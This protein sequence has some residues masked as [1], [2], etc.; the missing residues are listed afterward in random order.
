MKSKSLLVFLLALWAS[1]V[2]HAWDFEEHLIGYNIL[3]GTEVEVDRIINSVI[4]LYP[5]KYQ[6]VTIPQQVS[7]QNVS[8]NVIGIN[9]NA[10]YNCSIPVSITLPEG[11][12]TI[13]DNAFRGCSSLTNINLPESLTS[14]GDYAFYGCPNLTIMTIPE[15]LTSIGNYVFCGCS[16]PTS[17]TIPESLTDIGDYAFSSCT[18]LNSITLPE[19]V[20]SIGDHTFYRCSSLTSITLPESLTNIGNN[21]FHNCSSLTTITLPENL[22]TIGN[23]A[24][25]ACS[26]LANINFPEGLTSIGE[27]AFSG[28][29]SLTN[30]IIPEGITSIMKFAFQGCS[31]LTSITLPKTLTCIEIRSFSACSNLTNINLPAGLTSIEENAFYGCS[32]LTSITLPKGLTSIGQSAFQQCS[33]LTS[34]NAQIQEPFSIRSIDFYHISSDCVL[35]V[36]AGTKDAYI[37]KG[38][39]TD[40]F[41]GG[42]VEMDPVIDFVDS[43]VKAICV[44]NWDTNTDG[45]LSFAEAAAVTSLGEVFKEDTEITSF[46]E[47]QYFTELRSI[48]ELE[49]YNCS[50]L[51]SVR[52]P[53]KVSTIKE[54]A[55]RN[56]SKLKKLVIE[57]SSQYLYCYHSY[58]YNSDHIYSCFSDCPLETVYLGRDLQNRQSPYYVSRYLGFFYDKITLS[59]LE[60]GKKVTKIEDLMFSGCNGLT[61][62]SIPNSVTSIGKQSFYYCRNLASVVIPNS[63]TYIGEY[64][65]SG[66]GS[67]TSVVSNIQEPFTFGSYAFGDKLDNCV[68]TVPAG[69][70]DAYI[71]AG[72][73]EEVF[74]GG[75][76][77]MGSAIDFADANVKALCVDNWDTNNDGE[78]SY[79]E[80][81]AVT[82]LGTVFK[83]NTTITSFDE[84]Q[85]FTGLTS[86][87]EFAFNGCRGLLSVTFPEG[88]TEIGREAFEYSGLTSVKFPATMENVQE[89]AFLGCDNL[90]SID[91][92]N[93]PAVLQPHAFTLCPSLEYV[94]IPKTVKLWGWGHF[95]ICENLKT[96][97]SEAN[98]EADWWATGSFDLCPSLETISVPNVRSMGGNFVGTGESLQSVTILGG[99][100]PDNWQHYANKMGSIPP[101]RYLKFNIPDGMAES[102]LKHG[103]ANLSDL[104]ALPI[105]KE[106][107]EAEATRI[108]AMAGEIGSGAAGTLSAA[109]AAARTA[110]NAAEDYVTVYNQIASVK[111]AARAYLATATL[112]EGTDVAA[113]TI[114]NPDI[115]RYDIGWT[116]SGGDNTRGYN[117]NS[118]TNGVV[119]VDGFIE[120]WHE[121]DVLEDGEIW[122][123][124]PDLPAGRYRLE[125][126]AIAC[127]QMDETTEVTGVS[128]F[129]GSESRPIATEADKPQDFLLEFENPF[130]KDVRIGVRT[131]N[132]TANW[133]AVDNFRLIYIGP[134]DLY[135]P[136]S[137][138]PASSETD[139]VYL[140]NVETGKFLHAGNSLGG[141][142][143]V[144]ADTGLPFHLTQNGDGYWLFYFPE[145]SRF[146]QYLYWACDNAKIY[147]DYNNSGE[148]TRQWLFTATDGA[149]TLQF[150]EQE[151]TG[152][153]LGNNPTRKDYDYD[154]EVELD[155][156]VDVI[157]TDDVNNNIHWLLF[158]E[159][160]YQ[161]F[162]AIDELS[163]PN[164]R[165]VAGGK[166][167][168]PVSLINPKNE[169]AGVQFD[170]TLPEGVTLNKV[171]TAS[172]TSAFSTGFTRKGDGVYTV[173]L[174]HGND[175]IPENE[176]KILTLEM[177]LD[178]EME[179]SDYTIT[180]SE[181]VLS[182]PDQSVLP[183]T[184]V[185]SCT[186]TVAE[187]E[188]GDANCD[189]KVN[190]ADIVAIANYI[191]N[192]PPARFSTV[193]A[194]VNGD[195]KINVADIV[196]VAN[197]I[198]SSGGSNSP[199]AEIRNTIEP[200]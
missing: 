93:A 126:D 64:A 158:S 68:L 45:E 44:A 130:Q 194:N 180:I 140:Y 14:I 119:T 85:Y 23:Y 176:G 59:S 86:I 197:I 151:G 154:Y 8:Y 121:V 135:L 167:S 185:V 34:V 161:S 38:W 129:A 43:N 153:F 178:G 94:Y 113:A 1:L 106:E 37:A 39:T 127:R 148:W 131:R 144:L 143:A 27:S 79:E 172:R 149:Y 61:T 114:T 142:H 18:N 102:F 72:W 107:F 58:Y 190:V 21:A 118:Y 95:F 99:D 111:A 155:S 195:S 49:F 11:L 56:C 159:E 105:V 62:V 28:C 146:D 196:G 4:E 70:K 80:A 108:M 133:V 87:D 13:G 198:L 162:V 60:I 46:D 183:T 116:I 78:L 66:C 115:N 150:R 77:E 101:S 109:I 184:D 147:V 103:Y 55:F 89:A 9:A 25:A 170:V 156:H 152:Y 104:S 5:D 100:A 40:V 124:I 145:G 168:L 17:I 57:D 67:L 47:L 164:V 92:N 179:M 169:V 31:N 123:T 2:V 48:N 177:Q 7:Y 186:L 52:I 166:V 36:P 10:F 30:I 200:E 132:T 117:E 15:G 110:V 163:I 187:P 175:A 19:G 128:L 42:I 35:T 182:A 96:V 137:I 112:P 134:S 50:N 76:V 98:D 157:C 84:L 174:Y 75:I 125:L 173:L 122:Q 88:L 12:M 138:T 6:N 139:L 83:E 82:N 199:G 90:S 181:I 120:A 33:S 41:K 91:F 97:V 24:F 26:S 32:S 29:S 69:T 22:T 71:S 171:S 16:V 73:T 54:G 63:V 188:R 3:N 74:K 193:A 192:N 191:L 53:G 20:T 165:G 136:E 51:A 160:Q 81:A 141:Y 65:F 189:G